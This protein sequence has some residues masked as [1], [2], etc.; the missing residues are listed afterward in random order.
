[1]QKDDVN[2]ACLTI[3]YMFARLVSFAA[4][5]TVVL[6]GIGPQALYNL[7]NGQ[8]FNPPGYTIVMYQSCMQNQNAGNPC[9]SFSTFESS[10]GVYTNQLYGPEAA[11]SST[12]SRTFHLT[13][14]CGATTSMSGVNENP[15]CVYSA[16][17][18]LPQACGIDMRVGFEAASVSSTITP[19]IPASLSVT[20]SMTA[21]GTQ[22][23][24]VSVTSSNDPTV[25]ITL[26][27]SVTPSVPASLSGTLSASLIPTASI[28]SSNTATSTLSASLIPTSSIT[29]SN[30]ATSTLSASL[31]PTTTGTGSYTVTSS[32]TVTGTSTTTPLFALT[33][34]PSRTT[35]PSIPVTTTPLFM[36][37]AWP[38]VS[39]VNVSAAGGLAEALGITPGS[40]TAT[41][42]GAVAVGVLG[43][44]LVVGA[45]IY[46]KKGGSVSGLV[47][48]VKENKGLITKAASMLPLTEEQK[49]K[50]EAAVN[51]P[52][53]LLPK[54]AQQVIEVV[55]N[56]KEYEAKAISSLPISE[57]Q[58]AQL[59]SVVS[60]VH[61]TVVKK[62]EATE[63][64]PKVTEAV[65][66][67]TEAAPTGVQITK[68]LKAA[69]LT[70]DSRA[71][72][73]VTVA[74]PPAP[75]PAPSLVALHINEAD[76]EAV[77]E[78][79]AQK[80]ISHA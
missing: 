54:E 9:G 25:S 70:S 33:M 69:D 55:Q 80:E 18:T 79:L 6:G 15:T 29:S 64:A 24:T 37:T 12:C 41:I 38:T 49:A 13:L 11:V 57:A 65:P 63:A 73:T 59:T 43:V 77:R 1:M 32:I 58:K 21:T 50:V 8:T 22:T 56:A 14:A 76:I 71:A 42:L 31:I 34:Y 72:E 45:V 35:S 2:F 7:L 66:K 60:S 36:I 44:A 40:Q 62:T 75:A 17:L 10:N 28:T 5:A 46:F 51:D 53:A 30:T 47:Q 16:T 39:P 27:D 3:G 78:L 20:R 48:K 4:A 61:D 23:R 68:I 26:S 74:S 19:S 67:K 52:T